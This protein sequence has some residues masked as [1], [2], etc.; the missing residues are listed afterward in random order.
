MK[1]IKFDHI[2]YVAARDHKDDVFLRLK[3]GHELEWYEEE[4][5]NISGKS[6][7]FQE[8]HKTHD[9]YFWKPI[10]EELPIEAVFYDSTTSENKEP[11]TMSGRTLYGRYSDATAS[12]EALEIIGA[13]GIV[14]NDNKISCTLKGVLDKEDVSL[15]LSE[16]RNEQ[17]VYLDANGLGCITL[18]VNEIEPRADQ[19]LSV[20]PPENF[21]VNGRMLQI[22]FAECSAINCIFELITLKGRK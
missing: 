10:K 11:I 1:I 13:K 3:G 8:T 17:Q 7:F 20:T 9:L 18:I 15:V 4:R 14:H 21:S 22:S 2:T 6:R 19:I 5:E 16:G 12:A